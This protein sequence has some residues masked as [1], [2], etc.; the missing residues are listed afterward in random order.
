MEVYH[1]WIIVGIFLIMAEVISMDFVIS[2]FGLAALITSI[3]AY[4]DISFKWQL[5]VFSISSLF[6]FISIR[7]I[8]KHRLLSDKISTGTDAMIG[9]EHLVTETIDNDKDKGYIKLG[10][11]FWRARCQNEEIIEKESKIKIKS[12]KGSTVYVVKVEDKKE[13]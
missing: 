1:I 4:V 8:V 10:S 5:A 2:C 12:I 7:P 3:G 13:E 9:A 11:E 6:I